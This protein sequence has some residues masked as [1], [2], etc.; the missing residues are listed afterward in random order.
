[1][2]LFI[3]AMIY[4]IVKILFL[5][6]KKQRRFNND[7]LE[8]KTNYD[9]ELYKVQSEIQEQTSQEISRELHD[10]VGQNLSLAR[11]GLSTL[12]LD[13]KYEAKANID[14]ISGIIEIA[15]DD[16]RLLTRCM[17]A[18]IIKNGGLIKSINTQMSYIKRGGKFNAHLNVTGEPII[19]PDTKEIFL[20]RIVQE[21]INNIIRH[22]KASDIYISLEYAPKSL[23]LKIKDNGKGFNLNEKTSGPGCVS[24][25]YNMQR[26]AKII[27]A[28]FEMDSHVGEGTSIKVTTPY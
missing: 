5:V 7:L 16:L 20:F 19:L 14:E 12:E 22:S 24:G 15:L 13:K 9:L 1:M 18:E 28:D 6:Q 10:N 23:A 11:L 2:T 4:F 3:I 25:I 17:N 26:R 8:A 27:D 21:A